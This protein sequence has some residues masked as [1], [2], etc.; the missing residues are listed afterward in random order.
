[1]GARYV[2]AKTSYGFTSGGFY[3]FGLPN[4]YSPADVSFTKTTPKASLD[5]AIN[6]SVNV[7]A[8][9]AKGFRLGGP[10]GPDPT[11]PGNTCTPD[12][13][14]Y[15]ITTAPLSY[16]SDSLWSYETGTKG[17]Y[18]GNQ[19]SV[20]A[21]LYAINWSNIQQS[22]NL[23]SCGFSFTTNVGDAKIYG[24]EFEI[25]WA[26]NQALTLSLN[27]GTTHT[28][29]TSTAY[30]SIVSVGESLLNVPSY[31][32]T[33]SVDYDFAVND[34][35]QGFVRADFPYIGKSRAYFDS[36]NLPFSFA[37]N[38]GTLNLNVGITRKKLTLGLYAKNLT[39]N[40]KIIQ[41]PSVNSVQE[42]F[43]QRPLTVGVTASLQM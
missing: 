4:P 31:T 16:D 15:N 11:G 6:D 32:I 27:G 30:P 17:R 22:V 38:Y 28:F 39:D 8:S 2:S 41:Y 18:F 19:L 26:V 5:Y 9:V 21:A 40:K 36:A 10:T 25:R 7:Y 1:V 29:V 33:P 20:N 35:T 23:P 13:Q 12:Y 24:S 3:A 34:T 14:T 37:P 43:T 42:A